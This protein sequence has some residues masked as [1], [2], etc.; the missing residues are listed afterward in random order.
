MGIQDHEN[1]FTRKVPDLQSTRQNIHV[2][3]ILHKMPDKVNPGNLYNHCIVFDKVCTNP[4]VPF[5]GA[6]GREGVSPS[7]SPST[8]EIPSSSKVGALAS[9]WQTKRRR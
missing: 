3:V 7:P 2:C 4:G 8:S 6:V 5:G 1:I 9:S